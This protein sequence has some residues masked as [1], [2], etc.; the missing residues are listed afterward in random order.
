[1]ARK[2][3]YVGMNSIV[4]QY[5]TSGTSMALNN[6]RGYGNMRPDEAKG[7]S[8]PG[9]TKPPMPEDCSIPLAGKPR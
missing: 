6:Q 1:M 8:N 2:M 3:N 4:T 9:G 5:G 7:N